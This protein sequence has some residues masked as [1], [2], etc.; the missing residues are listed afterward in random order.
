MS[1]ADTETATQT[2]SARPAGSRIGRRLM[3]CLL[4]LGAA[5]MLVA[6]GW[7]W[8]VFRVLIG[9][10]SLQLPAAVPCLVA[11]S[12]LCN[13]A[14]ALCGGQHFLGIRHYDTALFWV[15]MLLTGAALFP[16]VA[17]RRAPAVPHPDRWMF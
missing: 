4:A 5:A 14:Q 7:W 16:F 12:D 2:L 15:G 1:H 10:A 13:L 8:L 11:S 9:N 6:V 17:R 3:G